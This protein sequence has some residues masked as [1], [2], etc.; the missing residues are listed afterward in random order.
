MV[1][2]VYDNILVP[3]NGSQ[4][5]HLAVQHDFNLTMMNALHRTTKKLPLQKDSMEM[6]RSSKIV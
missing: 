2:H 5:S 3:Y 1:M 6:V 4:S